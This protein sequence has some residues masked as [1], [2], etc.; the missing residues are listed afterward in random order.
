MARLASRATQTARTAG[1]CS[2]L[3][4]GKEEAVK[5]TAAAGEWRVRSWT[6]SKAL[7]EQRAA[8]GQATSAASTTSCIVHAAV[9][10]ARGGEEVAEAVVALKAVEVAAEDGRY[11][12]AT[13]QRMRSGEGSCQGQGRDASLPKRWLPPCP[14]PPSASLS[15]LPPPP[16][17]GPPTPR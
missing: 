5:S 15:A 9:D 14:S 8:A 7:A 10:W 1:E 3:S 13:A 6:A 2:H 16:P 4:G 11:K 12:C 17:L